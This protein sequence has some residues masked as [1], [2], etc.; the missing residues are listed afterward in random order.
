MLKYK[1]PVFC[2]Q[3]T[4]KETQFIKEKR[5]WSQTLRH[6]CIRFYLTDFEYVSI[7][8]Q[9]SSKAYF[10]YLNLSLRHFFLICFKHYSF[11]TFFIDHIKWTTYIMFDE[12]ICYFNHLFDLTLK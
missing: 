5:A 10:E 2:C 9:N 1:S 4:L 7:K 3:I 6:F 8:D 11:C 12:V